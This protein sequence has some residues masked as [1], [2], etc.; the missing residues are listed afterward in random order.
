MPT[1]GWTQ[2]E[3]FLSTKKVHTLFDVC[4]GVLEAWGFTSLSAKET[5][6]VGT[7]LVGATFLDSVTLSTSLHKYLLAFLGVSW[8]FGLF[9]VKVI[10]GELTVGIKKKYGSVG[11]NDKHTRDV[12]TKNEWLYS[13]CTL[14]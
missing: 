5:V 7:G 13:Y 10:G 1:R 6:Q 8:H 11:S 3:V 4:I 14:Q 12:R 2:L 9:G